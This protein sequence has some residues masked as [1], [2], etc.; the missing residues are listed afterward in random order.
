MN[1]NTI[2]NKLEDVADSILRNG[3]HV[4]PH[5]ARLCL[6]ATFIEDGFRM[7]FQWESQRD[8]MDTLWGCGY[9][10]AT[11]FVIVNLVG[12]IGGS[13]LI[14]IRREPK[15]VYIGCAILFGIV[16]LQTIAYNILF[17]LK[18]MMKNMALTGGLIL[19]IAE[20][21]TDGKS[22]FAGLPSM[23]ESNRRQTYFQLSGRIL[24]VFMFLTLIKF[25]FSLGYMLIDI[26]G[27][28][29]AILIAIG[30]KTK[31]AS[32]ALVLL[33]TIINVNVN[34]W[35]SIDSERALHDFLKYDF[36]QTLSVTGGLLLVV[37]LGPGGYS[38]DEH[39][40]KW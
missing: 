6:V 11:L 15:H 8:F 26:L 14:L 28:T 19:L 17:Q 36:F 24:L 2:I 12:Q 18:F 30:Y 21:S 38:V 4:L 20:I 31:L 25:E 9:I 27:T 16:L 34:H 22:L 32:L 3:K 13:L 35:W 7:W 5:V 33:L 23:G 37:A 40:K 29:L 1:K 10:L 39:K